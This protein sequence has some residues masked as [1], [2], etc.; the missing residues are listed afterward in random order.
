[1]PPIQKK[2]CL[3]G[4][5]AVGKTSLIRRFVEGRFDDKYLSTI[6]A[7]IDRK[8]LTLQRETGLTDLTL[9]IWDLAGGEKFSHMVSSYYRGAAGALLVCDLTRPETLAT[10]ERYVHE[11]WQIN[12]GT[13]LIMVGNKVDLVEARAITDADLDAFATP[14]RLPWFTSSAKTSENVETT[15]A[16]LGER[17]L[18]P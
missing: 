5:F 12:P 3:L 10:L 18:A 2:I 9:L 4:D 11:F 7:K 8:Q 1:M 15:F 14:R 17:L 6:G 13:P 16:L